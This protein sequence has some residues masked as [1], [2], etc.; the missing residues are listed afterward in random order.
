MSGFARFRT[1][2]L[3]LLLAA[4]VA[5]EPVQRPTPLFEAPPFEFPMDL[6]AQ[7]IEGETVLMIHIT[8]DGS[9]DSAY[10]HESSG[11]Q[12]FDSAA[13][14]AA[15]RLRFNPGRKGDRRV[16]VWAKLPVRFTRDARSERRPRTFPD[17]TLH[18]D[19]LFFP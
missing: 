6:W 17:S 16:H 13:V 3:G 8:A 11:Y 10:V 19:L 14:M 18:H 5:D 12:Q 9:V 15:H 4:C 7:G 1:G 2:A